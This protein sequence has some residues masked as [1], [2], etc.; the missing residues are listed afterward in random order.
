[1][2]SQYNNLMSSTLTVVLSM[3]HSFYNG[4][5]LLL[6]CIILGLSI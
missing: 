2:V 3:V 6:T 4:K 1:M 5:E